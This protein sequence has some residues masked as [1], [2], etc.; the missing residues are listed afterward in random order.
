MFIFPHDTI[1]SSAANAVLALLTFPWH[2]PFQYMPAWFPADSTYD[3]LPERFL[4]AVDTCSAYVQAGRKYQG[5]NAVCCLR[6][7]F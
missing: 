4:L 3:L 7:V 5:I 1:H 2:F 6:E